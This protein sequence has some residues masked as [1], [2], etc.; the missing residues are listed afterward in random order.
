M[1]RSSRVA[2]LL[3]LEVGVVAVLH[4]LAA[5]GGFRPDWANLTDWLEASPLDEVIGGIL[6]LVALALAYWLL[7]STTAYLMA[8][9]SRR[10]E[11]I[12]AASWMTLPP[13]R[14][15]VSRS[16][17][18]SIAAS[19][20]AVPLGPA[21]ADLTLGSRASTVVVEVDSEGVMR[22]PGAEPAEGEET[23]DKEGDGE[24]VLL[25]PHLQTPA[26]PVFDDE[27]AAGEEVPPTLDPTV[28][29]THKVARGDHLW[30]IACQH[31]QAVL[32]RN[33]LGEHEIAPYWVRVIEANRSTIRS[34]DP[35]LIYPG[36]QIVLPAVSG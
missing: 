22:P 14:R 2:G 32:G 9:L 19:S 28:T 24:D 34:G 12:R 11:A 30:S 8:S 26:D 35:D 7:F 18:L 1:S 17:A 5:R 15:L 6:T 33:D 25:P 29:H 4:A 36:E 21:V 3:M 16:V 20:I 23:D 27:P 13:I 10:P 31:L